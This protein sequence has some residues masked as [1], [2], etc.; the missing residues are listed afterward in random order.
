MSEKLVSA[1]IIE[2]LFFAI[3][4]S[5]QLQARRVSDGSRKLRCPDYVTM[6]E[7]GG[8]LSALCTDRF[9]PLGNIPGTHFC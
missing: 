8:R 4:K 6:A 3:G 7:D 5:I 2:I 1:P 9:L